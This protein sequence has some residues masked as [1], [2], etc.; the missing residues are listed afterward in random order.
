MTKTKITTRD[1]TFMGL[2]TAIMC[3]LGPLSIPLPGLVPISLGSLVIYFYPYLLGTRRAALCCLIYVLLGAVGLPVF[4]GY[5]GGLPKLLGPTGGYILGYFFIILFE[6]LAIKRFP[7]NRLV[8]AAGIALGTACCYLIGTLWLSYLL[9]LTTMQGLAAGVLPFI[10][11]DIAKAVAA[12]LIAPVLRAR[13][14]LAGL[15]THTQSEH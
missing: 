11:G 2:M 7:N 9:G 5:T 4:S 6:G 12:L 1:L 8:H 14:Q 10:P 13:L 15:M 3:A